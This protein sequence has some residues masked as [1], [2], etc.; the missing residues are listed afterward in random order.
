[1]KVWI[2]KYALT[3]GV[4]E[5]SGSIY[6]RSS[7]YLKADGFPWLITKPDWHATK[8]EAIARAEEMRQKKILSLKKQIAKLEKLRFE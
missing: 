1:M 2:T 4:R 7:N 8:K 5:A 6:Y 3:Q